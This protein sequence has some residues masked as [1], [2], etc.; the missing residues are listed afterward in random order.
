MGLR[1]RESFKQQGLSVMVAGTILPCSVPECEYVTPEAPEFEQALA[2]LR[3]HR[4][5]VHQEIANPAPAGVGPRERKP[6]KSSQ[7]E[8]LNLEPTEPNE[9]AYHFWKKRFEN[10]LREWNIVDEQEKFHKLENKLNIKVYEHVASAETYEQLVAGLDK[11]FITARGVNS[12]RNK[13]ITARQRGGEKIRA[14]LLRL[15][16]L[17]RDCRFDR[18]NTAE[19]NCNEWLCQAFIAGLE[20]SDVRLRLLEKEG[21]TFNEVVT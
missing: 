11:L 13:L 5:D 6:D 14:Y 21:I 1:G 7:P 2:L 20:S 4:V 9:A 17:A 18:P 16:I 19:D 8:D 12:T 10:Y 3:M 15:R